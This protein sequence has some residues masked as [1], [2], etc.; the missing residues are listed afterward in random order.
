MRSNKIVRIS[1][2]TINFAGFTR[3]RPRVTILRGLAVAAALAVVAAS[4]TACEDNRWATTDP[5]VDRFFVLACARFKWFADCLI[6][7]F[8]DIARTCRKSSTSRPFL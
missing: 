6:R 3:R 5:T 2:L 1:N 4:L 7:L 8:A